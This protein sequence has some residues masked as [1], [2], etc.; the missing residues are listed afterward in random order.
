MQAENI[1]FEDSKIALKTKYKTYY[2]VII[3]GLHSRRYDQ[4]V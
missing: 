1:N 4:L 3:V 2:D